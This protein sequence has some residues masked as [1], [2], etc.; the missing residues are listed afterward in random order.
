MARHQ[1][2]QTVVINIAKMS[3]FLEGIGKLNASVSKFHWHFSQAQRKKKNL[4]Y[5][6]TTKKIAKAINH[7]QK[8][9]T[10]RQHSHFKTY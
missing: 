1:G 5:I 7:K 6:G 3:T 2:S 4:K 10:Y 9:N 8:E